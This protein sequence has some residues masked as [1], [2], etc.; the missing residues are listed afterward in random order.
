MLRAVQTE[1]FDGSSLNPVFQS[2]MMVT[3][4]PPDLAPDAD[5]ALTDGV[6]SRRLVAWLIDSALIGALMASWLGFATGFTLLTLGLGVGAYGMLPA[7][8]LAYS[9]ISIASPL[10]ATPG[11]ALMGLVM[12]D[13][14]SFARP[15]I[16]Q[17]LLWIIGYWLTLGLLCLLFF[18]AIFT[19]RKRCLHDIVAGVVAVRRASLHRLGGSSA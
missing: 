15:T 6:L 4:V 16:V 17:A 11:Q 10:S 13:N 7:I 19:L 18:L 14:D 2:Q 3:F 5:D 9:W 12:L 8:P 1:A